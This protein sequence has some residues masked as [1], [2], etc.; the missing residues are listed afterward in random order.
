MDQFRITTSCLVLAFLAQSL[1][2]TSPAEA[3]RRRG[4]SGG[5]VYLQTP[6]PQTPDEH[7]NRGVELGN[8]GLW[9]DAI[10]EHEL[11]LGAEPDNQT[12]RTNLS[13]A[14]LRFGDMLFNKKDFYNAIKQ[15]RGSLYV[16]PNNGPADQHLDEALRQ[17]KINADDPKAREK[18]AETAGNSGDF[19]TAIV[20]WRKYVR[21]VDDGYSHYS[22]GQVLSKA[23]KVVE[24]YKELRTAVSRTWPAEQKNTL[25]DC[26]RILGDVLKEH[27]F[28]GKES[29]EGTV[30]MKRLVNSA[31]E[32]RRSVTINP[33]NTSAIS[34][35]IEVSREAVAIKPTSFDN[36]LMLAGAYQLAGDFDH[37]KQEYETC[38]RLGPN[39]PALAVAR[40]SFHSAL[41]SSPLASPALLASTMQSIQ[42]QLMRSPNDPEL[43][44]IYGRG[45]EAQGDTRTALAAYNKAASLNIHVHPDLARGIKRLGGFV[46]EGAGE[47][48]A[49]EK[50][51]APKAPKGP[52]PE[53]LKKQQEKEEAQKKQ[54]VYVALEEKIRSGKLDEVQKE[55]TAIVDSNPADAKAWRL[56]GNTYEKKGDL[57]QAAVSYRQA[58]MMKDPEAESMYRQINT[59][60]V[61]PMLNEADKAMAAKNWVQAAASLREALSIAPN[62]PIVHKRL[63]EALKQLGD[64]KEAERELKKAQ[65]L[66]NSK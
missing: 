30:G 64:T 17:T 51:A 15:Y 4:G 29:G 49:P 6:N 39:N 35:L 66:E 48:A 32:Y 21:M 1:T 22:L 26:H 54:Q 50:E 61:Q 56:L 5:G 46:A 2:F 62:L 14:Q 42:A 43:L 58:A 37:A 27:A 13:A 7:N 28:R 18:L 47:Q 16:D 53:E 34:G 38:Y 3:A 59:S 19:E 20:E 40:K 44:Y 31:I 36:H 10:R 9:Q 23:G 12:F 24:G 55:L 33:G 8:K 65:D 11:A 60:R 52:S 41:V 25:S 45:K 63:A 57:D